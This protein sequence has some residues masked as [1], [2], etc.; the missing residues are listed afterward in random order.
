ML[1]KM[2][3]FQ[4]RL[5]MWPCPERSCRRLCQELPRWWDWSPKCTKKSKFT[6]VKRDK[7]QAWRSRMMEDIKIYLFTASGN[8]QRGRVGEWHA[9]WGGQVTGYVITNNWFILITDHIFHYRN[10]KISVCLQSCFPSGLALHSVQRF[11]NGWNLNRKIRR[12]W[13]FCCVFAWIVFSHFPH[14]ALKQSEPT[15]SDHPADADLFGLLDGQVHAEVANDGPQQVLPIHQCR[16]CTLLLHH[17]LTFFG[18]DSGLDVLH[19]HVWE[20]QVKGQLSSSTVTGCKHHMISSSLSCGSCASC[21]VEI[22]GWVS[23]HPSCSARGCSA[24][25]G[26]PP[27][28]PQPGCGHDA[29]SCPPQPYTA[30][31]NPAPLPSWSDICTGGTQTVLN[32]TGQEIVKVWVGQEVPWGKWR[33]NGKTHICAKLH[34]YG[35]AGYKKWRQRCDCVSFCHTLSHMHQGPLRTSQHV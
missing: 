6:I 27:P 5:P 28:T 33:K 24:P 16:G 7:A 1:L 2:L 30:R 31:Q 20:W 9:L 15:V 12:Q 29:A 14:E 22:N 32:I 18:A 21:G 23:T 4:G 25:C 11:H 8:H 26:L 10:D 17:R 34:E 35:P 19:V 3:P 13:I